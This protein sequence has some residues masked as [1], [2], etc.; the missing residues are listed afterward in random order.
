MSKKTLRKI[1]RVISKIKLTC[2]KTFEIGDDLIV[3][4]WREKKNYEHENWFL[5]SNF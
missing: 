1:K 2:Q 4:T 5:K 3:N